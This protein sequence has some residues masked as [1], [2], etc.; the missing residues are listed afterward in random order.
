M[1]GGGSKLH[2]GG[3]PVSERRTLRKQRRWLFP[4]NPYTVPPN[5]TI[6]PIPSI[7]IRTQQSPTAVAFARQI[8]R[9][10]S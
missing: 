4:R 10:P 9:F 7:P 8:E 3:W 1:V 5:N 6:N 2:G